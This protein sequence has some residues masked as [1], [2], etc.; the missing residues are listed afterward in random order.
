MQSEEMMK[1]VISACFLMRRKKLLN[2][3][4]AAFSL[5]RSEALEAIRAAGLEEGVRGEALSLEE[6]ARLADQLMKTRC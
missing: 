6:M 3:L 1:K 4:C 5:G 2:N